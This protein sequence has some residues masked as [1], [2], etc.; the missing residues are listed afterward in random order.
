[1]LSAILKW[2]GGGVIGQYTAPLLQAYQAKLN[3]EGSQAK[4]D[5]ELTI[6]R[7]EAARDI[8]GHL[9]ILP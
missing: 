5:A 1:V 2:L 8:A 6:E 3:A 7:I 4:L 9:I